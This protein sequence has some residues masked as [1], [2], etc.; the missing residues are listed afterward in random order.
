VRPLQAV[1]SPLQAPSVPD[2]ALRILWLSGHDDLCG[3]YEL[4]PDNFQNDRPVYRRVAAVMEAEPASG[5]DLFLWYRGGN[6]GVTKAINT[7]LLVAPFLARCGDGSGQS[8]HPLDIR[9]P[10]W[11]VRRGRG[12]EDLDPNFSLS[13]EAPAASAAAAG[14][15]EP[16]SGTTGPSAVSSD[17]HKAEA[18][19]Q[20][21]QASAPW[22]SWVGDVSVELSGFEVKAT[23]TVR[24]GLSIALK[25]LCLDVGADV[26]KVGLPS[27]DTLSIALPTA[28]D[29]ETL[30][31]ARLSEKTRTLKVRLAIRS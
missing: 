15:P 25:S 24:E 9:R 29:T 16:D 8:R 7:S 23:I 22:P 20:G 21:V 28:V 30:P 13:A 3:R 17:C 31:V 18:S 19:P 5:G 11:Q 4:V 10:R 6:W 2:D 14:Y 27:E 12:Q 26:L 1:P